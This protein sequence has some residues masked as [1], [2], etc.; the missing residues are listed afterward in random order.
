MASRD[1]QST[2]APS[3]GVFQEPWWLDAV[4]PD[5]WGEITVKSGDRTIGRFPYV[6]RRHL[7]M[8]ALKMPPLNQYLGPWIERGEGKYATRLAKE[9]RILQQLIER[10]PLH[11]SFEQSL[12]PNLTN[13]L[14]FHWAGFKATVRY[15]YRIEDLSN[16][17]AIWRDLRENIRREVRKAERHLVVR[18]DLDL[19]RFMDVYAKTFQRQGIR[20]P[21][22]R[23]VVARVDEACRRHQAGKALFA[24]DAQERVHAVVY[25]VWNADTCFYLMSGAD[26]GLR[27]SGAT[28]LLVW[29]GIKLARTVS[30]SFDFEGSMIPSVE[31]F[32]R[33]FGSRQT[34]YL[35]IVRF[36]PRMQRVRSLRSAWQALLGRHR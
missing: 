31:R 16:L 2:G 5:Q 12:A 32:M 36:S 19:D 6:A 14:P 25:Y 27:S 3:Y 13:W 35:R 10:L 17:E 4:A 21:Y 34:P 23:D 18:D 9:H 1:R 7:G 33:G 30:A 22:E 28:S 15:T 8:L 29:E 11:D 24:V 26:A 20:V